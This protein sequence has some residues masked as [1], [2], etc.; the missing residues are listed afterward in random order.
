YERDTIQMMRDGQNKHQALVSLA[1]RRETEKDHSHL[2]ERQR[3][4]VDQILSSRDQV[5]ALEGVAGAGK[6][7][8]LSAVRHAAERESY[9]VEAGTPYQQLQEAGIQ[10][11]RLDEIVRQKDPALKEVVEQLSLGNVREAIEKL[12]V[13]GRVHE[14][15]DRGER[16]KEIAREYSKQPEGTL[17]VSPDNQSRME[18]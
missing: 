3:A 4:A 9:A 17:V 5:M 15:P 2:S 12:D 8:S 18:I 6:T 10:T 11:A 16:L 1:T 13:H 14:I 7:T